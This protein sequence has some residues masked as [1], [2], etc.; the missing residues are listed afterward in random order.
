VLILLSAL[1][2]ERLF[3]AAMIINGCH[4][5]R[6]SV[7]YCHRRHTTYHAIEGDVHRSQSARKIR[8][9]FY[10]AEAGDAV[11]RLA[12]LQTAARQA[13]HDQHHGPDIDTAG[14]QVL[15]DQ[16]AAHLAV[17]Q[18]LSKWNILHRQR[19]HVRRATR[20]RARAVRRGWSYQTL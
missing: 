15:R 3:F 19:S 11:L 1:K 2:A 14:T 13:E 20:D 4:Y 18:E 6:R 9:E 17:H 8:D 10:Y 12:V 5:C 7:W 16:Q